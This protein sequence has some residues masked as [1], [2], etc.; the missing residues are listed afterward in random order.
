[1][2]QLDLPAPARRR[3]R[4]LTLPIDPERDTRWALVELLYGRQRDARRRWR[5]PSRR[6]W[7]A[8][9]WVLGTITTSGVGAWADHHLH[10]LDELV[11]RL[12]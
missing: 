8:L 5:L 9:I 3:P 1:M 2:A 7:K 11:R 12:G 6:W 4:G 10:V